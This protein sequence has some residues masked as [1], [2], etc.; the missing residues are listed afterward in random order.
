V[1]RLAREIGCSTGL[2][3]EGL[4][5]LEERGHL[6]IYRKR[7][8]NSNAGTNQYEFTLKRS[9]NERQ[10]SENERECSENGRE[11]EGPCSGRGEHHVQDVV[12]TGVQDVVNETSEGTS[13]G[14]YI[15]NGRGFASTTAGNARSARWVGE[16]G[17]ERAEPRPLLQPPRLPCRRGR[18]GRWPAAPATRNA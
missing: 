7:D 18:F 8:R 13:E 10:C 5:G 3:S 11:G 17:R 9:G 14:T 6:K 15:L 2:V 4:N 1:R 16:E 12:N